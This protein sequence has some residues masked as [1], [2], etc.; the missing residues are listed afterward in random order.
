VVVPDSPG[1]EPDDY[2]GGVSAVSIG[3]AGHRGPGATKRPCQRP[4]PVGA[5]P[6]ATLQQILHETVD[7]VENAGFTDVP[8]VDN[9]VRPIVRP[10]ALC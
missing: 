7:T 9:S 10:H 6:F 4:R 3:L 2:T 5:D 8:P 1:A